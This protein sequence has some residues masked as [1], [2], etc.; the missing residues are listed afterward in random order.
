MSTSPVD[1]KIGAKYSVGIWEEYEILKDK[2]E[3]RNH[4]VN[5]NNGPLKQ[6]KEY[7]KLIQQSEC[8][9]VVCTQ[10]SQKCSNIWKIRGTARIFG[11]LRKAYRWAL[12]YQ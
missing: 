6:A 2:S 3:I 9:G 5:C 11:P 7:W 10:Q 4:W 1:S 8:V 12:F